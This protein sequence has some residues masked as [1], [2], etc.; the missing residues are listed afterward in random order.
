[1]A[2]NIVFGNA[3]K[4]TPKIPSIVLGTSERIVGKFINID[5]PTEPKT[6]GERDLVGDVFF[7][8]WKNNAKTVENPPPERAANAA[9]MDWVMSSPGWSTA[10]TAG[11]LPASMATSSTLWSTLLQDKVIEEAL[12]KQEE[13]EKAKEESR[14]AAEDALKA[15]EEGDEDAFNQLAALAKKYSDDA[16]QISAESISK[17]KKQQEDPMRKAALGHAV[18]KAKEEGQKV[19]AFTKAWGL[20]PSQMT[21]DDSAEILAYA[22]TDAMKAIA[23][24]IG[25][26]KGVAAKEIEERKSRSTIAV[27]EYRKTK[28]I[29][30]M[31]FLQQLMLSPSAPEGIRMLKMRQWATSGLFGVVPKLTP[32]RHGASLHII[33]ESGSM[34]RHGTSLEKAIAIGTAMAVRESLEKDRYYEMYGFASSHRDGRYSETG[35][36]NFDSFP[37]VNSHQDFSTHIEWAGECLN[38]GTD[39]DAAFQLVN[40]RLRA[41]KEMGVDGCDLCFYSDGIAELSHSVR[42]EFLSIKSE[43]S[44][45]MVFFQF[46]TW[47][48]P[49]KDLADVYIQLPDAYDIDLDELVKAISRVTADHFLS[50]FGGD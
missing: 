27:S 14:R 33:D 38:G 45:R 32:D 28:R 46:G 23:E 1:M 30:D 42:D 13:A 26:A 49:V 36:V 11:N 6:D 12:K 37:G 19:A 7:A 18:K 40:R 17:L 25:R 48:N 15:L 2:K 24:L 35:N 20:D 34:G 22:R 4:A 47:A 39:F 10:D 44:V 9:V 21:S 41:I 31:T 8:S 29:S 43:L 50:G 3:V 16:D 5:V